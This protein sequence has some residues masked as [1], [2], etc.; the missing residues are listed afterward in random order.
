MH[1]NSPTT[2]LWSPHKKEDRDDGEKDDAQKLVVIE[3]GQ[4]GGLAFDDA[5]KHAVRPRYVPA[6]SGA[7]AVCERGRGKSI[8]R[9]LQCWIHLI[10]V[11]Y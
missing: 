11:V 4:H 6:S 5:E 10:H 2:H 3:E 7:S 8:K 9:F 1:W